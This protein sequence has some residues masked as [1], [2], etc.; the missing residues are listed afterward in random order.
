MRA[1]T[2]QQ[3][4][5]T[6]TGEAGV[7]TAIVTELA[8]SLR[9]LFL[10]GIES[11]QSHTEDVLPPMGDG[12]VLVPWP[13]RIKDAR[14]VLDGTTQQLDISEPAT[15]NAIHGLLRNTAYQVARQTASSITLEATVFP[16]HGY[17]FLLDTRV[18]YSLGDDGLTVT[19]T[20]VNQSASVAPVAVGAHPYLK[21][22]DVPVADLVLRVDASTQFEVDEKAIPTAEV[23][24][25]GSEFDLRGGRR[26][27]EVTLDHGFGGVGI[28]NGERVHSVTAPDGSRTELWGDEHF[29]FVQVYTPTNFPLEDGTKGQAVAIEPMTAPA[30]AFNTGEGLRQ[31]APGETWLLRWG[32]RHRA[33][34]LATVLD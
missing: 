8:A 4:A 6:F 10:D 9:E 14:W 32:I 2:G 25:D 26:V 28:Q 5:L 18:E 21:V 29:R 16:Q 12:I 15:G 24:L 30:N 33:P 27:G 17:P 11:T 7:S 31:L 22:G 23:S 19:H 34:G 3:F 13:N 20:I 1:P